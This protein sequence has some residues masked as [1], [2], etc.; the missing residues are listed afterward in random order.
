MPIQFRAM[1]TSFNIP[2]ELALR[3]FV[4]Y[5]STLWGYSSM[6][7]LLKKMRNEKQVGPIW[8]R[9]AKAMLAECGPP[10]KIQ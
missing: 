8:R 2:D 10:P 1:R 9:I 4:A 6:D 5:A 7:R 3:L